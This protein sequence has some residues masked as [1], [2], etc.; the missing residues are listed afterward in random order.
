MIVNEILEHFGKRL[1]LGS[2]HAFCEWFSV[3]PLWAG[4]FFFP[5]KKNTLSE[6]PEIPKDTQN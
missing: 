3:G 4:S 5:F 1:G 6:D 2:T